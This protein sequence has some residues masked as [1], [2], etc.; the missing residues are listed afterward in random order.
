MAAPPQ[1][2]RR[3]AAGLAAAFALLPALS[4]CG[5]VSM[6]SSGN[7]T[8]TT[9]GFMQSDALASDRMDAAR[10][11]LEPD[12]LHIQVNE[13]AFDSQQFLSAVAAGDA[14]DAVVMDRTLVGGY[15]ARGAL[16]PLTDCLEREHIDTD[17]YVRTAIDEGSLDGTVYALPDSYDSRLLL[18]NDKVLKG[19]GTSAAEFSTGNWKKLAATTR[20]LQKR[21]GGKLT[22]IGFDPKIP[23]FF[24]MWAKANGA[25][26]ISSDGRTAELNDPK[27]VQALTYAV[28]LVDEQGGWGKLKALRDSFDM[29]G[30]KNEFVREQLGSFPMEDWYVNVLAGSSPKIDLAPDVFRDRKG[31]PLNWSS[32]LGWAIPKNAKHPDAACEFIKT[33]TSTKTW[34]HAARAKAKE[35]RASGSPYTGDVTGNLAADRVIEHDVWKPTGNK[36]FDKATRIV[37]DLSRKGFAVP[38]NAAGSEFKDA[39]QSAVNRVLSG[40]QTP[41]QALDQAQRKA[42]SALDLANE[43][44]E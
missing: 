32:G 38:S 10:K 9:M 39:W 33:M 2:I 27:A 18:T 20:T 31:K 17:G 11:A 44:R 28:K 26:L 6:A 29:F 14:P 40:E 35:T 16:M 42:Q 5:G 3:K 15:A 41:Q 13:G 30:A 12:G 1:R 21:S 24:P 19:N 23:E 8:F 25:D 22:R 34:V 4:G 36:A 7:S 43:G 37:F